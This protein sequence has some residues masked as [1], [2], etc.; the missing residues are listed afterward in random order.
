MPVAQAFGSLELSAATW[1]KLHR[2]IRDLAT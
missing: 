1:N 2:K